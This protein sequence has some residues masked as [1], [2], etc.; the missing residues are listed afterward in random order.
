MI[1]ASTAKHLSITGRVQGVGFR[2]AMCREANRLSIMGWVRNRFDGSVEAVVQGESAAVDKFIAWAK[3]GPP[4][5]VVKAVHV[6][7]ITVND[8]V[9]FT[10]RETA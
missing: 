2:D 6:A 9:G 7:E 5:A 1:N 4:S 8:F 3:Q 10:W